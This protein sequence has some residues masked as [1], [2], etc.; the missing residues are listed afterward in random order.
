MLFLSQSEWTIMWF[1]Y[2]WIYLFIY[3]SFHNTLKSSEHIAL[4][5]TISEQSFL[6]IW[7]E[8]IMA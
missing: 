7:K 5:D 6:R 8:E 4:N 1:M 3:G 2:L